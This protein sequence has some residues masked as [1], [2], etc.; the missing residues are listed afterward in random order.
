[1]DYGIEGISRACVNKNVREVILC[2]FMY[3]LAA[4]Q[5]R[6]QTE[7]QSHVNTDRGVN[8]FRGQTLT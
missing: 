6:V 8:M 7:I 4:K 3:I 5:A 1:M 2:N